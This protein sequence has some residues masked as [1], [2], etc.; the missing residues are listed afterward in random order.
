MKFFV[1][2]KPIATNHQSTTLERV[3]KQKDT[4]TKL[5]EEG[6]LDECYT[7]V[8]GGTVYI[9]NAESYNVIHQMVRN[10]SLGTTN[11]IDI[12]KIEERVS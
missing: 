8:S 4:I 11:K 12:Y 2:S 7:I 10:S 3:K 1:I 5:K 6:I 9:I